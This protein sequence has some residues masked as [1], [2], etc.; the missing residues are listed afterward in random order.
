M[1][2]LEQF[3]IHGRHKQLFKVEHYFK[4]YERYFKQFKGRENL[5]IL[6]IGVSKGGSLDMWRHY[7]GPDAVIYGIDIDPLAKEHESPNTHVLILD[8]GN[9]T[10]LIN[11]FK[12]MPKFDIIIDD[13]GH[14]MYQQIRSFE[15]LFPL[16]KVDGVYL[17]EDTQ[18][19]YWKGLYDGGLR[20]EHTF[21]EWSKKL[22]D[23]VNID[24][25]RSEDP[26]E[27]F[28]P[29]KISLQNELVGV[30]YHDALVFFEKYKK[31]E[32]KPYFYM[33]EGSVSAAPD[34]KQL[35]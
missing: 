27:I 22:V 32:Q 11:T 19:S 16:L 34:L 30:H 17:V 4:Y 29:L 9:R 10:L 35:K 23:Y 3:A 18:T 13:G 6:E 25:F 14:Y 20:E 7:F 21:I 24:H 28:E 33:G 2:E 26:F 1:S 8:Q 5:R 15:A 12:N 31:C